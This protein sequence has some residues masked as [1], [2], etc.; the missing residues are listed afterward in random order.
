MRHSIAMSRVQECACAFP[1]ASSGSLQR[2]MTV[3]T[4]AGLRELKNVSFAQTS[5]MLS[6]HKDRCYLNVLLAFQSQHCAQVGRSLWLAAGS[7]CDLRAA[8]VPS[9]PCGSR[10]SH[11]C[12]CLFAS[13]DG[14]AAGTALCDLATEL[15]RRRTGDFP[16]GWARK[17]GTSQCREHVA[18]MEHGAG[19]RPQGAAPSKE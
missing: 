7:V 6:Q 16:H 19:L 4:R 8:C 2:A 17:K 12:L 15:T 13:L 1:C 10:D 18:S 14:A 11:C 3:L 9:Y 5:P